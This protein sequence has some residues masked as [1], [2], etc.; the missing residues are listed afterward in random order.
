MELAP[1]TFD[2]LRRL[3]H[4]LCGLV[5]PEEKAYL[6]RHRLEPLVRAR[7]C[8]VSED[9]A[10]ALRRPEG[11]S[12]QEAILEAITTQETSFFRDRHLFETF[13]SQVLPELAKA[14]RPLG[15]PP[16]P[17]RI[18]VAGVAT[19]Q[20]AYSLAMVLYDF[21]LVNPGC[22]LASTPIEASD[23][24]A[25]LIRCAAEATYAAWEV[26]RGLSPD[27]EIRYFERVADQ[28]RVR[29][30]IRRLVN[31]R[32]VNLIQPFTGLGRFEAIFC[33]NVLIYF[34]VATRRRICEQFHQMLADG[35]WLVLG[36]AEN[37]YGVFDGF[38]SLRL[39]DT[40][41]FRKA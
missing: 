10:A 32:R 40:L 35:G 28:W 41:L 23:I 6:V 11:G 3:V 13:R 8:R 9:L 36:A 26:K 24:S 39:G 12:L 1:K 18:W 38:E 5:I 17:L 16:R 33:R 37:L 19:G 22:S 2:E 25:A 14:A 20:E 34:D 27:Q 7:D 31:F 15:D 4:G 21:L 30:P 29:E